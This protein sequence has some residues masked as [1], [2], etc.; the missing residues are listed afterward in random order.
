[1]SSTSDVTAWVDGCCEFVA[2][3]L[4]KARI[5]ATKL[6]EPGK[7]LK[8]PYNRPRRPIRL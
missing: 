8:L 2:V 6:R 4:S 1:M 7:K 3:S 5:V